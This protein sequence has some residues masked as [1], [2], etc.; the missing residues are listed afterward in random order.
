MNDFVL[1]YPDLQ[2]CDG[3]PEARRYEFSTIAPNL[4]IEGHNFE[5]LNEI[6]EEELGMI[7]HL[8]PSVRRSSSIVKRH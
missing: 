2:K 5:E 4:Q 3:L 6:F 8:K 1:L 7:I